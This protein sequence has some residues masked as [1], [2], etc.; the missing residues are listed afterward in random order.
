[1]WGAQHPLKGQVG[2]RRELLSV[3]GP[4]GRTPGWGR[5]ADGKRLVRRKQ[6]SEGRRE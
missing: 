5:E 4:T 1:M 6:S 3:G 2:A